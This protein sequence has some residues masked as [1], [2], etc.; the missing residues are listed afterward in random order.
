M[1]CNSRGGLW[2]AEMTA[3]IPANERARLETLRQY[4]ILDTEA[5]DGFNDLTSIASMLCNT[6]IAL[7][8]LVDADRQWAKARVGLGIIET[9]RDVSF[10][11][12]AILQDG[13][14]VVRDT[15]DDDRFKDNRMVLEKPYIRFYAGAPLI[16]PE[17]FKV[18]T[19]CVMDHV[20][21]DISDSQIEGLRILARQVV[22][23]LELRRQVAFLSRALD[24]HRTANREFR[25][26]QVVG[27]G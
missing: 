12:H 25:T 8:S 3:P 19:L 4:T 2:E 9:P 21:R 18:G 6:P 26:R 22:T 24:V 1:R 10:C 17:G 14:L 16:S 15:L 11:A 20:P 5:E 27:N 23:L 13:P 7:I